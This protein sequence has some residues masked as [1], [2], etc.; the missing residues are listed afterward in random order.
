MERLQEEREVTLRQWLETDSVKEWTGLRSIRWM[1][2]AEWKETAGAGHFQ[3]QNTGPK[4]PTSTPSMLQHGG[5]IA[6]GAQSSGDVHENMLSRSATENA[7]SA[8]TSPNQITGQKSH[9]CDPAL[10]GLTG[11]S[12][13]PWTGPKVVNGP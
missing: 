6:S 1:N 9:D 13:H 5:N 11:D 12:P 2:A 3:K 10:G 7:R 8:W 4:A